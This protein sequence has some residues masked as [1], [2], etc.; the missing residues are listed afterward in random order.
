MPG[1][2]RWLEIVLLAGALVL[3]GACA[4]QATEALVPLARI[5]P[6]SAISGL[7][8]YGE[9]LWFVNSVKYVDHNS[10]DVYSF[11][12]RTGSVEYERHLFSQDAGWPAVAGGLLYWPFEDA[13]FSVGR[14]EFM[15]TNGQAWQWRVIP[16]GRVLH[17]HAMLSHADQLYAATGGFNASLQRS[18]DGGLTWQIIDEHRNKAGSFSRLI[19][20][21]A[22]GSDLYAG[23]YT[24][25]ED[26]PK[27]LRLDGD[28]LVPVPGWPPGDD[29]DQLTAHHGWLY[30]IHRTA[31]G[32]SVWRTNG[33]GAELVGGLAGMAVRALAAGPGALW[34][35]GEDESGGMLWQSADGLAWRVAQRFTGDRPIDLAV[36][37]G[38]PYVGMIGAD[39]RGALWGPAPPS[40]V[41]PAAAPRPLPHDA[42]ATAANDLLEDLLAE[43]DRVL[44]DLGSLE[45]HGGTLLDVLEPIVRL[46]SPA[47][48]DALVRRLGGVSA[49]PQRVRFAG[50]TVGLAEK[51]DWQLLWAMARTGH[52]RVPLELLMRPWTERPNRGEKY[53]AAPPGAAWVA[54]ELKQSD[55]ATLAALIAHLGRPGDPAWLRG[56]IIGALTALTGQRFGYDIAAWQAWWA[57]Q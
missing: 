45:A 7:V 17:V 23:L 38:R 13:R 51:A 39:G 6:W 33:Q 9:R 50:R 56:D 37:A 1:V 2:A 12:P 26:G 44:G 49:G 40:S 55:P 20:L 22:L 19:S 14:G 48:G 3:G 5:G 36:Y 29:A 43:L 52:G 8:G 16:K 4:A 32:S 10:A 11:N 54:G 21:A 41:E 24:S 18:K 15:V 25:A 47:A 34:A 57:K 30:A 28:R 53:V 27:L 31:K 42:P 46:R 35:I